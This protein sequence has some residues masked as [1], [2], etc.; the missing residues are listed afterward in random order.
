M[1][2]KLLAAAAVAVSLVAGSG[3]LVGNAVASPSGSGVSS[4]FYPM[5]PY[6]HWSVVS[7]GDVH[8]EAE[9]EMPIAAQGKLSW[10]NTNVMRK[11]AHEAQRHALIAGELDFA[12]SNG[13]LKLLSQ[14]AKVAIDNPGNL[15]VLMVDG[16]GARVMPRIVQSGQGYDSSPRVEAQWQPGAA[17]DFE[18][19]KGVFGSLFS[20]GAASG[21]AQRIGRIAGSQCVNNIA[22]VLTAESA[23]GGRVLLP[24]KPGINYWNVSSAELNNAR[25]IVEKNGWPQDSI[26]VINVTDAGPINLN[27]VD[28]VG[29]HK[30]GHVLLNAPN[31]SDLKIS[32]DS[33]NW[34]ILAPNATFVKKS[35]NTQGQVVVNS[36]NLG[37]SEEH[38]NPEHEFPWALQDCTEP[39]TE[40]S[41]P[42]T[43]PSEPTTEP[44][45]PTEPTTEPTKPTTEPTKPTTEP[46]KPTTEPS[47]PTTE[48]SSQSIQP[49]SPGGGK[50]GAPGASAVGGGKSLAATGAAVVPL[51]L[52]ATLLIALGA[53]LVLV[54]RK[55]SA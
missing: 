36:A 40:P 32:G 44:S 55:K 7:F 14:R 2:R 24:L 33:I 43:E 16:N 22:N 15:D 11:Y 39:T 38:L 37:G 53:G 51:A 49:A 19:G 42:T 50:P 45:E 34:S 17:E 9:A 23:G 46:T 35:A 3:Y 29:A 26:L 28:N 20:Q 25:E 18:L 48:P 8:I 47:E 6:E 54:G 10:S 1:S 31:V 4:E 13:Q 21:T 30:L 27:L 5:Q 12:N 41:E 52:I